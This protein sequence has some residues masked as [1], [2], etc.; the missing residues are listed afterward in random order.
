MSRDLAE[1]EVIPLAAGER[2]WV[3]GDVH[4]DPDAGRRVPDFLSFLEC[5]EQESDRLCILGD[6]FDY[7]IGVEHASSCAYAPVVDAL[8]ALA[9][10]GYPVD[11]VCGNRDFLGP[12]ELEQIGLRVRG[13]GLVYARGDARTVVTHGDLLVQGDLSYKRYRRVVRSAPVRVLYLIIPVALRNAVAAVIRRISRRKLGRIEPYAIPID[14]ARAAAWLEAAS[15]QELLMGH[16]HRE[17]VHD[18]ARGRVAMLPAWTGGVSPYF[19]LG[20]RAELRLGSV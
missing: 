5:A 9:A 4:L 16:L 7:W 3:T 8:I 6:L 19:E 13:N 12:R 14:L 15:A 11:F 2:V 20:A 1:L 18:L 10:R 17:E